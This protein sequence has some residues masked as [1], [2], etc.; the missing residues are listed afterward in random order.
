GEDGRL[1]DLA[2]ARPGAARGAAAGNWRARA[3]GHRGLRRKLGPGR[4]LGPAPPRLRDRPQGR[5]RLPLADLR[6]RAG[7]AGGGL[8][9]PEDHGR[10]HAPPRRQAYGGD[11]SDAAA[12]KYARAQA[13]F[14]RASNTRRVRRVSWP[15]TSTESPWWAI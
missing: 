12:R 5:G 11:R 7:G 4:R 1:R 9:G 2:R 14:R 15:P 3:R 6:S 10:R 8:E 13:G